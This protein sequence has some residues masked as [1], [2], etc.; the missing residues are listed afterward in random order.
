MHVSY[1]IVLGRP[2]DLPPIDVLGMSRRR[3]FFVRV[4]VVGCSSNNQKGCR[5]LDAARAFVVRSGVCPAFRPVPSGLHRFP[6]ASLFAILH[7][8]SPL[9]LLSGVDAAVQ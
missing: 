3:F 6:T 9:L 7:A 1:D 5:H 2:A 8:D 4:C